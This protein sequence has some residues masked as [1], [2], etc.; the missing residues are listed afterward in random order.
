MI[1]GI[2]ITAGALA[3]SISAHAQTQ[4]QT[5]SL[6]FRGAIVAPTCTVQAQADSGFAR[7]VPGVQLGT[8]ARPCRQ[9]QVVREAPGRPETGVEYVI[10][11][12]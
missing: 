7:Q 4:T 8:G 3:L 12:H 1:R 2:V 11:Y 9:A 6:A 10:V 5:G